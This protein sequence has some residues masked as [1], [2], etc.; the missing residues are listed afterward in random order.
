MH[1]KKSNKKKPTHG[2]RVLKKLVKKLLET[3]STTNESKIKITARS[4]THKMLEPK[5][6]ANVWPKTSSMMKKLTKPL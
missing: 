4:V 6:L 3:L 1:L 2:I 5:R